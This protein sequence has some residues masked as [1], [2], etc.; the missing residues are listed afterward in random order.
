LFREKWLAEKSGLMFASAPGL[1]TKIKKWRSQVAYL[2]NGAAIEKFDRDKKEFKEPHDIKEIPHPRIGFSGAIDTFKNNIKL[3]EKCATEYK[4]YHFIL[5]GPEKVSDPDL[6]LSKLKAMDN[7][8]FL[9]IKKWEDTP[10]Y[11]AYFDAYFIPYNLNDYLIK[12]CFPVKYFE[13]LAAGLPTIVT[14]LP[15][16]EG[17]DVDGYVSKDDEEFILNIKRA[18]EE[19]NPQ[20]ISA[21]KKLAAQNSWDGKVD[22]QIQ[23]I[24]NYFLKSK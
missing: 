12:G 10:D 14:K 9:G 18:L 21:R 8:R 4:D 11:F 3:I 13:A 1:V 6:D 19:N 5:I 22:K 17:F 24:E 20:K 7:V 2:P 15:A 16:Y 23:L